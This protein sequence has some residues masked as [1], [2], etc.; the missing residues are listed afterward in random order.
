MSKEAT[1]EHPSVLARAISGE[2]GIGNTGVVAY[3]AT[4]ETRGRAHEIAPSPLSSL[5]SNSMKQQLVSLLSR[6]LVLRNLETS[7]SRREK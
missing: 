7:A 5:K 6:F 1:S 2:G 3:V 4:A